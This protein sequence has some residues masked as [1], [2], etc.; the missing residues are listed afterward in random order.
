MQPIL[1]NE[2]DLLSAQQKL[3]PDT[4]D[5]PA[6]REVAAEPHRKAALSAWQFMATCQSR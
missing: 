6:F 2:G 4:P 1:L 5:A 3:P